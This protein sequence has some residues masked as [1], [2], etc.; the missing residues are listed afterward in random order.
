MGRLRLR[1][2][3]RTLPAPNSPT[4]PVVPSHPMGG[5]TALK[6][7]VTRPG[8]RFPGRKGEKPSPISLGAASCF[9]SP[10]TRRARRYCFLAVG[11]RVMLIQVENLSKSF[12][13]YQ[14][15]LGLKNSFKNLF[16]RKKLI[17]EAVRG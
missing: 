7:T 8:P 4:R 11:Y 17:K 5:S 2:W 16:H 6:N 14:K 12:D 13:Y 1:W 3:A 10:R 15:E 9:A